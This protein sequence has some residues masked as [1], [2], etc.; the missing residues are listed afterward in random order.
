[1]FLQSLYFASL[2]LLAFLYISY[3]ICSIPRS[4]SWVTFPWC[5]GK[6]FAKHNINKH[7]KTHITFATKL[8]AKVLNFID[9]ATPYIGKIYILE[10]E[11]GTH[12]VY[13][14][15]TNLHLCLFWFM[16]TL[17]ITTQVF[18]LQ[19]LWWKI[20]FLDATMNITYISWHC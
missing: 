1:M 18:P 13:F 14:P 10:V 19:T 17:S 3:K 2:S 16:W 11:K 12:S 9:L 4:P 15:R 7:N 20:L 6:Q 5:G 8:N